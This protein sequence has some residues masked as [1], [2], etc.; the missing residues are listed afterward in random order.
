MYNNPANRALFRLLAPLAFGCIVY[1]LVLL[2]FDTHS[3]ILEDFFNQELLVCIGLSYAVLE[4]NR[5]MAIAN[6]RTGRRFWLL[7][8]LKLLTALLLTCLVTSTGLILYFRLQLGITNILSFYTELKVFN[9]IFLFIALLYQSYFLGF[10]WLH[11]KY[12]Q[13]LRA[14]EEQKKALDQQLH[15][16]SYALHPDFLFAGLENIILKLREEQTSQ[17]DAGINLLAELYHY[18]LRRQEELVPL[19]EELAAVDTLHQL[20]MQSGKHLQ[21]HK[22]LEESRALVIPVSLVRLVEAIVQSQLSS[23]AAPLLITISQEAAQLRISFTANFSLTHAHRLEQGLQSLQKQY[24]WLSEQAVL[25][26][27]GNT[28]QISLP[29]SSLESYESH[30]H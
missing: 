20:L 8:L 30:H 24:A 17:A 7:S 25:S 10:V 15:Q 4:A 27:E 28:Y 21:I 6:I 5:L 26:T 29:T 11:Y 16:F 19:E 18:F 1:L 22:Q 12:Q 3:R 23:A 2:A 13:Q 9:S 14:E